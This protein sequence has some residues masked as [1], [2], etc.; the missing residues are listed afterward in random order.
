MSRFTYRES[1]AKPTREAE[2]KSVAVL[3][4]G[5]LV[6]HIYRNAKGYVYAPRGSTLRGNTYP[7]V[8]QV[9]QSLESQ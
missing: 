2:Y 1:T 6:G 7:T 9:K 8:D 4:D 5:A 3:L